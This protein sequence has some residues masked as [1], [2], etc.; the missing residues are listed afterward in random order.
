MP[1]SGYSESGEGSFPLTRGETGSRNSKLNVP[2]FV[3]HILGSHSGNVTAKAHAG[4]WQWDTR[5]GPD[6]NPARGAKQPAHN[7]MADMLPTRRRTQA[8]LTGRNAN[9]AW[10]LGCSVRSKQADASGNVRNSDG[11]ESRKSFFRL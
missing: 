9:V 5:I 11:K 2:D 1:I 3:S 6:A 4:F 10:E 7:S 8:F